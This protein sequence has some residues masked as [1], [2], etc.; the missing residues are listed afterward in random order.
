MKTL[1][2][3]LQVFEVLRGKNGLY[4]DKTDKLYD[5]LSG[6]KSQFF[7][8]RPRRFG[9]TLLCWTLDALFSGKKELFEGL[10]ISKTDWKWE[11]YPVIHLDMSVGDFNEGVSSVKNAIRALLKESANRL[12]IDLHIED[13]L[14]VQFRQLINNAVEK[15]G[16]Q[17]VVIIDEYDNPLLSVVEDGEKFN[18][19]RKILGNF[20]K[21]IKSSEANLRFAFLTGVTKF[22][23]VSVFSTLNN[24]T[25]LTLEPQFAD[26]CG[27]TQ[28]E[29]ERDFAGHID[30]YAEDNH[31]KESYLKELK[32]FY[33]GYRFSEEDVTVYNPYGIMKHFESG[34]FEAYW[35]ETGTPNYLINLIESQKVNILTFKDLKVT[36][37]ALNNYN[38]EN[39]HAVP[40]LYQA[41]YLTIVKYDKMLNDYTLDY[42]NTEVRAAFSDELAVRYLKVSEAAKESLITNITAYLF[43]GDITS[44]MEL[45]LKPFMAEIPNNLAIRHE[46]Y[47]QTIFHIIFN[48]LGLKCRSE[49]ATATGRLDTVVETPQYVYCFEFKLNKTAEEAIKQIDTKEYL[50]PY[51]G[52]G[53]TLFKVGVNFDYEERKIEK[54]IFEKTEL[55]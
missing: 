52:K 19:V 6:I 38:S 46:H 2:V 17:A 31:G 48:M 35:F 44:A 27:I 55:S 3:G 15:Y 47:F 18:E 40:M 42:P 22:A 32:S 54:W 34:K 37:N 10:A 16:K 21:V 43:S 50:I 45:V 4:V 14:S 8:S 23:K 20:Y 24:L 41:G 7:L 13:T 36:A 1:P 29:L 11:S 53:K 49:V 25:D 33:N 26:L 9:K 12:G 28:E 30:K 5:I 39:V 51:T